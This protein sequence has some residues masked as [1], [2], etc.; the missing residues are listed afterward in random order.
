MTA[1]LE[2]G[3]H[4]Y[5]GV[6]CSYLKPFINYVINSK[7]L[8]YVPAANEGDAVAIAAGS[9]L[10]GTRAVCMFQ[11]SGLGNAVSPLSSLTATFKIPVLLIVTHRGEPGASPDEPQHQLMGQV[12]PRMIEL[13]G[14]PWERFPSEPD[15]VA[16]ALDR[17]ERSMKARSE[18]YALIMSKGAVEAWP[19]A[20]GAISGTGVRPAVPAPLEPVATRSEMLAAVRS[21]ARPNDILVATTGYTGRE[22]YAIGDTPNQFYMVGSMGCASSFGL[23]LA[24]ARPRHRV[25]VIDGD[26]AA[27]MRLGAMTTLG[28]ERPANLVHVVLDN[29]QHE[30]TGGQRTVTNTTDLAAVA[31]ACGYPVVQR[32]ATPDQLMAQ[33]GGHKS[34]LAFIHAPIRPGIADKLPRPSVSPAEVAERLRAHVADTAHA[35]AE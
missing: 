19:D 33:L 13:L 31:A 8:R 5:T 24:I 15:A 25:I 22:L 20:G 35:P 32:A 34:G 1:A 9:E 16:G 11:N 28:C 14:I 17:A 3:F 4:L 7:A 21:A 30:S 29:G 27:I 12:T 10:G 26:G 6:P 18:P 2:R 23:G